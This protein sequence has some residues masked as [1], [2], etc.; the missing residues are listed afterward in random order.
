MPLLKII[1]DLMTGNLA[2]FVMILSLQLL[3]FLQRTD[4][5]TWM[6]Y[7]ITSFTQKESISKYSMNVC[8]DTN[9]RKK[10]QYPSKVHSS[11]LSWQMRKL[12]DSEKKW[13][14]LKEKNWKLSNLWKIRKKRRLKSRLNLKKLEKKNSAKA[15]E[16]R[17]KLRQD[18]K[19]KRD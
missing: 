1:W 8:K 4:N 15:F 17:R 13:Q 3:I 14:P 12:L 19:L 9:S 7:K 16:R 5:L 6:K 2:K 11:S 10:K 18:K